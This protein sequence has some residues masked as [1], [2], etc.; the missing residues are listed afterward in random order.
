MDHQMDL[1]PEFR[2]FVGQRRA[3][4]ARGFEAASGSGG[5]FSSRRPL[6]IWYDWKL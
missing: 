2:W 1:H 5:C 6:T 4:D 3:S